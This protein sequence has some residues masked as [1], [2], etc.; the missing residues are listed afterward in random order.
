MVKT[1]V[2]SGVLIEAYRTTTP[3]AALAA[4]ILT[5]RNRV[6]VTSDFVRLEVLPKPTYMR[7]TAEVAF[8]N[9]F[10]ALARKPVPISKALVHQAAHYA[11]TFGLSAVDALHVAAAE[12]ARADELVTTE[13][14]SS[15]LLRV[16]APRVVSI[17]P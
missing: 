9:A 17:R 7:R 4:A 15:P 1:Y 5:D 3:L 8:Y 6:F 12:R 16:P 2:D 13:R 14:R 10:F 11:E